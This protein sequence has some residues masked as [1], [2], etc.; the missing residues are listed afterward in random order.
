MGG[1]TIHLPV[2][3]A[4]DLVDPIR[5]ITAQ[6]V[7][8][9]VDSL[10]ERV[11]VEA[12]DGRYFAPFTDPNTALPSELSS[13]TSE[14]LKVLHVAVKD[15]SPGTL[16]YNLKTRKWILDTDKSRVIEAANL[17]KTDLCDHA[18]KIYQDL[19]REGL[20]QS[21]PLGDDALRLLR[22]K[23]VELIESFTLDNSVM[24]ARALALSAVLGIRLSQLSWFLSLAEASPE[25]T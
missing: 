25:P 1:T 21:P 2:Y 14:E 22:E 6:G 9:A 15:G 12:L 7:V 20:N 13:L 10:F 17:R 23:C 18:L 16:S 8:Y 4:E 24:F 19:A 5:V 11:Y 3:E